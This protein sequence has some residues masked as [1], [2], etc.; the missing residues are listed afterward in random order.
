[1]TKVKMKPI[2]FRVNIRY[3]DNIAQSDIMSRTG[4]NQVKKQCHLGLAK[5]TSLLHSLKNPL[6][7]EC[8][9]NKA[10]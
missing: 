3:F 2:S 8:C 7:Y 10:A 4:N 9:K 6:I 5:K 1:M